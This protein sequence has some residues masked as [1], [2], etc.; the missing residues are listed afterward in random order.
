MIVKFIG[1]PFHGLDL[2]SEAIEA[3]LI[4][5]SSGMRLV[6]LVD[7]KTG[8]ANFYMQQMWFVAPDQP[9]RPC[10]CKIGED[11]DDLI[12]IGRKVMQC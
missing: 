11:I 7:T 8:A 6:R 3:T 2:P 9:L 5:T 12:E 1:G 4:T 10:Y